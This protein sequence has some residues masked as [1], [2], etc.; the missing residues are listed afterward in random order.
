[1]RKY[2]ILSVLFFYTVFAFPQAV[3]NSA[4]RIIKW[5][6]SIESKVS[7]T[8]NVKLL[9]FDGAQYDPTKKFLPV[10]GETF[11]SKFD[12]SVTEAKTELIND[13]YEPLK[14]VSL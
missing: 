13:V 4:H 5:N 3:K 6:Q 8:E 7:E 2:Y 10:Y 14:D 1:M 11:I 12:N 9:N